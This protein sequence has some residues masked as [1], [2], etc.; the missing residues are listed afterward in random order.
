[1]I[2]SPLS[3]DEGE[4]GHK[5]HI[6]VNFLQHTMSYYRLFP[7]KMTNLLCLAVTHDEA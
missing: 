7:S 5:F 3:N 1:M 2:Y 4:A 6:N